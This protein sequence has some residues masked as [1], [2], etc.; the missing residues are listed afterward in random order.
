[1]KAQ[2]VNEEFD[3]AIYLAIDTILSNGN[4]NWTGKEIREWLASEGFHIVKGPKVG[5]GRR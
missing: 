2:D 5:D 3:E 4:I 1:M